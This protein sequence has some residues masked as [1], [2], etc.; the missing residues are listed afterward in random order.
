MNS[1][2]DFKLK[3]FPNLLGEIIDLISKLS[4][5]ISQSSIERLAVELLCQE[6]LLSNRNDADERLKKYILVSYLRKML[7]MK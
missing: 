1:K 3:N 6:Y 7:I 4:N 2:N 5:Q